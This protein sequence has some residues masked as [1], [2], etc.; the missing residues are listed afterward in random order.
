MNKTGFSKSEFNQTHHS[1]EED[2]NE[3]DN[4]IFIPNE[5]DTG[6]VMMFMQ[7]MKDK[8][9]FMKQKMDQMASTFDTKLESQVK[10]I[11]KSIDQT[12]QEN[13]QIEEHLNKVEQRTDNKFQ[14]ITMRAKETKK[15]L[16]E[17]DDLLKI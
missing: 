11:K 4:E 3:Q 15:E 9:D 17:L 5:A 12:L 6:G 1:I 2:I 10:L 14:Q 8:I 7:T 13:R 16:T